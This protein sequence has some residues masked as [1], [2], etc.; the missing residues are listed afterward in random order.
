MR[1]AGSDLLCVV[2]TIQPPTAC[3]QRLSQVLGGAGRILVLGDRKGPAQFELPRC[4][5]Y[6]LAEQQ[7]LPLRLAAVLPANHYARKNLG[8]LLAIGRGA[9][10]IY[11]TDDDNMPGDTWQPRQVRTR[12]RRV[13]ARPWLNVYRAFTDEH[14]WPRGFPLELL[15]DTGASAVVDLDAPEEDV[16][17]PI[18]QG[19][20][21]L[22]PD[23]DAVWRLTQD[24]EFYFRPGPSLCLPPGTWCPF[25]SQTTWWWPEA[26]PLLYLPTHCSFRMTDIWRGFVAQRCLWELGHGLVFHGPEVI[27]QR[28]QHN[29]LRDFKD[30]VPGY[31][32]NARLVQ[33]LDNL[34][35]TAGTGAVADN[36]IR[37]YEDLVAGGLFPQD[38]LPLV[39]AWIEDVEHLAAGQGQRV[40]AA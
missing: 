30:E 27:Q 36:V 37:C 24:R 8:Y 1:V 13:P 40:L 2:T 25:N 32:N 15:A 29:L 5:F 26:Y 4:E 22:A 21:D 9:G 12:A 39:R 3:V 34:R 35:L 33:R 38:E 14:I 6:S 11:E 18:Q 10:C 31:L 19:L 17:A 20:A 16:Y 23:V 28:N 7:R